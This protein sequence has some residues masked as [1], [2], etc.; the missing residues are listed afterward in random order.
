MIIFHCVDVEDIDASA[1]QLI[2]ELVE[3]YVSRSVLVSAARGLRLVNRV[4]TFCTVRST[5]LRSK[6]CRWL[7]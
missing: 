5:G 4:D 2:H 1:L 7:G 3:S 6:E